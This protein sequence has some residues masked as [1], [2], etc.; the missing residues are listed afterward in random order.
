MTL[1]EN[2]VRFLP[3]LAFLATAGGDDKFNRFSWAL[4]STILSIIHD[5]HV[6]LLEWSL[7]SVLL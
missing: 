2:S 4:S 5:S 7:E 6:E 3:L 1:K